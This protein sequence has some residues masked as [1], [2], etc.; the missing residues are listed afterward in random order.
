[1]AAIL[2]LVLGGGIV[3]LALFSPLQERVAQR[4]NGSAAS[5]RTPAAE[6]LESIDIPGVVSTNEHPSFETLPD[7]LKPWAYPD[8]DISSYVHQEIGPTPTSVMELSS[9]DPAARIEA[10]YAERMPKSRVISRDGDVVSLTADGVVV[11]IDS[12]GDESDISIVLNDAIPSL[13]GGISVPP[14]P[15]PPPPAP[16][17]AGN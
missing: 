9:S 3:G 12:S 7:A 15:P 16:A 17:P 13:G 10:W 14:V 4:D 1:V 6:E 2:L 8:A 11:E 5:S